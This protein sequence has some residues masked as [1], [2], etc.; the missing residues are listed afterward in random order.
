MWVIFMDSATTN[1]D[2]ILHICYNEDGKS[3]EELLAEGIKQAN[4]E[5]IQKRIITDATREKRSDCE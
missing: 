2:K 4:I 3:F 1:I 5:A